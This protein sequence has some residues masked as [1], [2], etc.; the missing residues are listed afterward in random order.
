MEA[1]KNKVKMDNIKQNEI[2]WKARIHDYRNLQNFSN[3]MSY[4]WPE[5]KTLPFAS[6]R[7]NLQIENAKRNFDDV[8]IVTNNVMYNATL[9]HWRKNLAIG[10]F[11][12]TVKELE[13]KTDEE[14][15]RQKELQLDE[16]IDDVEI[17]EM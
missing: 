8:N 11:V 9:S 12:E 10:G 16:D 17:Q 6:E 13:H 4:V 3:I 1:K 2:F 15:Q 7:L 5:S 14:S